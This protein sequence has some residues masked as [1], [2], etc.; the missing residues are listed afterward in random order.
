MPCVLK[1]ASHLVIPR[2]IERLIH[3]KEAQGSAGYTCQMLTVELAVQIQSE[4][5]IRLYAK[6]ALCQEMLHVRAGKLKYDLE[7][8]GVFFPLISEKQKGRTSPR[9]HVSVR[10]L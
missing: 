6:A 4:D 1:K 5:I 10:E 8:Q 7:I 9:E 3:R 2:V